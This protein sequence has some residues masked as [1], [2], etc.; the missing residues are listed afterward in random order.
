MALTSASPNDRLAAVIAHAGTW[1]SWFLAPLCVYVL[2]RGESR[3]VEFHALQALIWSV[4]GT[5][6]T[7]LTCG[8]AMP[9]F[10]AFH[11]YAAWKVW[12]GEEYEYPLAGDF[13][14]SHTWSRT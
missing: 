1:F 11:I 14:R 6:A 2:K 5:I 4:I 12:K 10:L 3:Y 7:A 9:V 13:A 8:L